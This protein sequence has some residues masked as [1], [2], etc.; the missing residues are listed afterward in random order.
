MG[1]ENGGGFVL[2]HQ[3]SD[4]EAS[5]GA[6]ESKTLDDW[7]Q[8]VFGCSAISYFVFVV[9]VSVW[10]ESS[11]TSTACISISYGFFFSHSLSLFLYLSQYIHTEVHIFREKEGDKDLSTWAHAYNMA[12]DREKAF[13]GSLLNKSG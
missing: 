4:L 5:K 11:F 1:R 9:F 8:V 7:A 2:M 6:F 3:K 10:V 13:Q 12:Q